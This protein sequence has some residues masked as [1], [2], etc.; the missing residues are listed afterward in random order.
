MAPL[1]DARHPFS[2]DRPITQPEEDA[3]NRGA[4]CSAVADAIGSWRQADSLVLGIY[5]EWGAGKSSAKN[6]VVAALGERGS[7]VEFNPWQWAGQEQLA[8]AFFREIEIA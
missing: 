2:A 8:E 3:L 7:I 5:G 4:F 1:A 6:L